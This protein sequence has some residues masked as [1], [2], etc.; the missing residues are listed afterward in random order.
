M[1]WWRKTEGTNGG[2]GTFMA[3]QC[4]R[5]GEGERDYC[6][7]ESSDLRLCHEYQRL[8]S[9]T[10]PP[11][12]PVSPQ[13][14]LKPAGNSD[15]QIIH[16]QVADASALPSPTSVITAAPDWLAPRNYQRGPV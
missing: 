7:L 9:P 13:L 5:N 10:A 2:G 1:R 3:Q 4:E 8:S 6:L 12:S 16:Q 15:D 11:A 14:R